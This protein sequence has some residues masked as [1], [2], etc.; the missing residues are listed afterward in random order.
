MSEGCDESLGIPV[1]ERCITDQPLADRGPSSGLDEVC[2]ERSLISESQPFQRVA[3][4]GL[5]MRSPDMASLGHIRPRDLTG[6]Q[7]FL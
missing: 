6:E 2:L 4:E 3:H 7:R 1:P 5:A